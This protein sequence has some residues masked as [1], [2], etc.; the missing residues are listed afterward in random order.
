MTRMHAIFTSLVR[1]RSACIKRSL[2]RRQE[3][4]RK[5]TKQAWPDRRAELRT[6]DPPAAER[7]ARPPKSQETVA[8][9][10]ALVGPDVDD[11]RLNELVGELSVRSFKTE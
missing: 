5:R 2:Q 11:P 8:G 6:T 4:A 9:L 1:H 10:R 7:E 3:K